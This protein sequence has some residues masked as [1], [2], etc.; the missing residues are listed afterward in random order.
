MSPHT[1]AVSGTALLAFNN[2][3]FVDESVADCRVSLT[4]LPP[5][6]TARGNMR[7]GEVNVGFTGIYCKG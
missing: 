2:V 6:L 5:Y 1:G 4:L 7:C 3:V